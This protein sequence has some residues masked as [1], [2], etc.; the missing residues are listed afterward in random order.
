MGEHRTITERSNAPS[1]SI[2]ASAIL[3]RSCA[4]SAAARGTKTRT[5]SVAALP[6][7]SAISAVDSG[8]P[9]NLRPS[10][11]IVSQATAL[12]GPPETWR[13]TGAFA[14][15]VSTTDP[16][17]SSRPYRASM[18]CQTPSPSVPRMTAW[19]AARPT[20]SGR[21]G[22]SRSPIPR[23]PAASALPSAVRATAV[24]TPIATDLGSS[25]GT[26]APVA[27]A[28]RVRSRCTRAVDSAAPAVRI[29]PVRMTRRR[30]GLTPW[31]SNW[32]YAASSTPVPISPAIESISSR[33]R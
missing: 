31:A 2:S 17:W 22:S 5:G 11:L 25:G 27:L 21:V 16:A 32:L 18:P 29:S 20:G 12:A 14:S 24:P 7:T 8:T 1:D 9:A 15:R 6:I 3:A 10:R 30:P 28:R 19:P 26:G 33:C 23:A 4:V 13:L